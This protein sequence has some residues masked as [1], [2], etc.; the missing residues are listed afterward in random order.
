MKKDDVESKEDDI[1]IG[2]RKKVSIPCMGLVLKGM[3]TENEKFN[4]RK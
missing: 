3:V 2:L 4:K 1:E